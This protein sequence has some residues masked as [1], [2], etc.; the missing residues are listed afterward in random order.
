MKKVQT[1]ISNGQLAWGDASKTFN[2][3]VKAAKVPNSETLVA[4]CPFKLGGNIF[5]KLKIIQGLGYP[6]LCWNM[7][8]DCVPFFSSLY[9]IPKGAPLSNKQQKSSWHLAWTSLTILLWFVMLR[10]MY[11]SPCSQIDGSNSAT[12]KRTLATST[13]RSWE[14]AL[15]GTVWV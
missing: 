4:Q 11:P 15:L 13:K 2:S 5:G 1:L 14:R 7:P 12:H 3:I 10:P 9:K 6:F 8:T